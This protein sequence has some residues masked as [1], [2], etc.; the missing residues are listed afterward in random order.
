MV[1][2]A[3]LILLK[4]EEGGRKNPIY[5]DYRASLFR[6]EDNSTCRVLMS[7]DK[8]IKPGQGAKV[9]I[10]ILH[11]EFL[12]ALEEVDSFTICE[13]NKIIATGGI[14]ALNVDKH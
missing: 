7:L 2:E 14:L 10:E 8:E 9:K 5:N 4:T 3:Y 6:N 12:P 1:I 13:G 11:P